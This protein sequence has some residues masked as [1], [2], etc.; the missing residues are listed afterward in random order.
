MRLRTVGG[1]NWK[2][3]ENSSETSADSDQRELL[4][5]WTAAEQAIKRAEILSNL[6]SVPAI[7]ELRHAGRRVADALGEKDEFK[8]K[9]FLSD[10]NR[11]CRR[12][13]LDALDAQIVYLLATYQGVP[14]RRL[15]DQRSRYYKRLHGLLADLMRVQIERREIGEPNHSSFARI[16]P[17]L[18]EATELHLSLLS[19]RVS[20]QRNAK[21]GRVL[22]WIAVVAGALAVSV[23]GGLLPELIS[24]LGL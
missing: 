20:D 5:R 16:V 23:A 13:E 6:I 2:R 15:S 4:I 18:D 22:R 1:G 11:F 21:F 3:A 7:N 19:D 9:V 14:S 12:A 8:R 24:R 17:L 10:A